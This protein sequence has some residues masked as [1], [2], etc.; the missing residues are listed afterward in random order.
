MNRTLPNGRTVTGVPASF[1]D[2]DMK[3]YALSKGLATQEDYNVNTETGA[4]WFNIGG[5]LTGG[6]AGAIGG[7][8][9]GAMAGPLGAALGGIA[10]GALGTFFGSAAGQTLEA[11][12]EDRDVS[13]DV[14]ENA[15]EAAVIDAGAGVVFGVVG[16]LLGK[17]IQPLYRAVVQAPVVGS[18]EELTQKAALDVI[19][20]RLTTEEATQQYGISKELIGGFTEK[21]GKSE[22]ERLEAE[23]LFDKLAKQNINMLPSQVPSAT[24]GMLAKQEIAQASLTMSR[25]VDD[26][27]AEQNRFITESFGE[28]LQSTKGLS[29]DETGL[30]VIN[31]VD[32]TTEALKTTVAPLYRN[33]DIK[34]GIL[35]RP[36]KI[37]LKLNEFR[38]SLGA[39]KKSVDGVAKIFTS[40]GSTAQPKEVA[41]VLGRLRAVLSNKATPT[42]A[43]KYAAIAIRELE[44]TLKGPQFVK[45][46]AVSKLGE[47]AHSL[48]INKAGK[49]AIDGAFA[50]RANKLLELRPTMSFRE[51]HEELSNLK[52]LQRDMDASL[53]SKDSG[54]SALL[55]KAA[56]ALQ[57]QMNVT[58]KRFNPLLKAEYDSV[59]KIYK[60]GIETIN[61]DWI[62]KSLNKS[63]PALIG[64]QLVTAGETMGMSQ[65]KALMAKAKE[66]KST[67]QGE[68]IVESIRATY[69]TNLFSERTAQEAESFAKKMLQP[70]FKDTFNAIVDKNTG[71]AL[72]SLAKEVNILRQG[73]VG[74]ES[75]AS[76]AVRG[77]EISGASS[78][79]ITKAAVYYAVSNAVER[80]LSPTAIKASIETAKAATKE[81][82]EKGTI[83]DSMVK[84][85]IHTKFLPP[86][87]IGQAFGV[88][89]NQGTQQQ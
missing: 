55:S 35:I 80:G 82:K 71:D 41:V 29:R 17:A 63:N 27:I 65:L 21:L 64:E 89:V 62:V 37:K 5:E 9:L 33:I 15:G 60:E 38:Q 54:A 20:G 22:K 26:T 47:E 11:Q 69:L 53:G 81:L 44:G 24:K 3:A 10:G 8:Q 14:W 49:S 85:M 43:K 66:L 79:S 28:V 73:L 84:R 68:N 2:S 57:D 32:A 40:L 18:A 74:T 59:S 72:A 46:N 86:Y 23:V 45:T 39:G 58:A 48:L 31:L 7:A 77:R 83:S 88:A 36:S 50:A 30:A 19:Q 52:R 76:L 42:S 1:S 4:D 70:R 56:T 34:G 25:A 12:V 67:N 75:A 87:L 78:P 51:A 16:K 61:G 6:V 13:E